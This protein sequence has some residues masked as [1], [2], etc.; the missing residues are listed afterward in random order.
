MTEYGTDEFL[1][2][3]KLSQ[4]QNDLIKTLT[5]NGPM[6]RMQIVNTLNRAKTTVHNNL[7][8]LINMEKIKK[9]S[10]QLNSTGRPV[11]FFKIKDK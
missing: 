9:F 1:E 4:L 10:Q 6:T 2:V 8:A 11:V 7:S 5:K 3:E